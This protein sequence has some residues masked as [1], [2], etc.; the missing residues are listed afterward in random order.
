MT[1]IHADHIYIG[2]DC[3]NARVTSTRDGARWRLI[4]ATFRME[5]ENLTQLVNFMLM[6]CAGKFLNFNTRLCAFLTQNPLQL[7]P[8]NFSV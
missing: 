4:F 2:D 8:R 3:T 5:R 1:V 7:F 6:L